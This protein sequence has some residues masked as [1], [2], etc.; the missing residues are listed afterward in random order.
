LAVELFQ[1]VSSNKRSTDLSEK[2]DMPAITF[3]GLASGIDADAVI[4]ALTDAKRVQ[5]LPLEAKINQAEAESEAFDAINTTMLSLQSSLNDFLTLSGGA[6]V[7]KATSSNSDIVTATA[8]TNAP[9]SSTTISSVDQLAKSATFTFDDRFTAVDEPLA[10]NLAAP[11]SIDV[12]VGT[13]DSALLISVDVDDETTL[14]DVATDINEQAEGKVVASIINVGTAADP[15]YT[16][17]LNTQTT[18]LDTGTLSVSVDPAITNEGVF[19]GYQIEQA[20]DAVFTIAGLGQISKSGNLVSGLI[21]GISFE[22]KQETTQAA[23]INVTNDAEATAIKMEEVIGHINELILFSQEGSEISV[24]TDTSGDSVNNYGILARTRTDENAIGEL[25]T[26]LTTSSS[27]IP[28]SAIQVFADLG[29]TTERD[30]TIAF[31]IDTF[32][33]AINNEAASV[34]QML[35]K[36]ADT[37]AATDGIV[38]NYTKFNGTIDLAQQSNDT[39]IKTLGE[40]IARIDKSIADMTERLRRTFTNLESRTAQLQSAGTALQSVIAGLQ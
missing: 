3:S 31:K 40:Q 16:L 24:D 1:V 37:V 36:F 38:G 18:G 9:T 12:T 39:E 32:Q 33:N 11:A 23:S 7:K 25:R 14:A 30:G 15:Q 26:A 4:E 8:S 19:G 20:Q 28:T 17:L 21:P 6:I 10:Q 35:N 13:G 5:Q 22:L 29:I 34:S 27:D 2:A